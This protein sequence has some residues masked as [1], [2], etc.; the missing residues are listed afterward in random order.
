MKKYRIGSEIV[1]NLRIEGIGEA[2]VLLDD[3]VAT[4]IRFSPGGTDKVELRGKIVA[5]ENDGT[6]KKITAV[7][8]TFGLEPGCYR[9][10]RL[11]LSGIG[12]RIEIDLAARGKSLEFELYPEPRL[13]ECEIGEVEAGFGEE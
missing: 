13:G 3:A 11:P 4:A 5:A 8:W 2:T 9:L 12:E 7:F 6:A 10:E 1:V